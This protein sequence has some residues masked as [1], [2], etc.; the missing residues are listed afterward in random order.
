MSLSEPLAA[1]RSFSLDGSVVDRPAATFLLSLKRG[2]LCL[3]QHGGLKM[4]VAGGGRSRIGGTLVLFS[5]PQPAMFDHSR[6]FHGVSPMFFVLSC[7]NLP[8]RR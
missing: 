8:G 5:D 2:K 7:R 4:P 6:D 3:V 1:S